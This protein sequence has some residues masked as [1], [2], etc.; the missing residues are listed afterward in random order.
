MLVSGLYWSRPVEKRAKPPARRAGGAGEAGAGTG[1]T[2]GAAA[3]GGRAGSA[4][5]G[6]GPDGAGGTG[7][8]APVGGK[9]QPS[10]LPTPEP[11]MRTAGLLSLG[12]ARAQVGRPLHATTRGRH[13]ARQSA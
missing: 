2:G 8:G 4:G 10:Q 6:A 5:A 11:R 9:G 12:A 13:F 3:V 7:Q 1:G